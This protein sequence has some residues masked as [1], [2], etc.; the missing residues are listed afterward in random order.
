[1]RIDDCKRNSMKNIKILVVTHK[2]Y[3]MPDDVNLYLPIQ[4][5]AALS[6]SLGIQRDDIGDNISIKNSSYN[7]LCPM[8]WAWKNLDCDYIGVC[9]YRRLFSNTNKSSKNYNDLLS[10]K[11]IDNLLC[12][13]NVVLPRKSRFLVPAYYHYVHCMKGY[14]NVHKEDLANLRK[15]ICEYDAS[16]LK[17]YDKIMHSSK[18]HMFHMCIMKKE[19][20]DEYCNFMFSIMAKVEELSQN[21]IDKTR[22]IGAL[23]EFLLDVWIESQKIEYIELG[24]IEP[25]K[26]FIAKKI[27]QVL[28]RKFGWM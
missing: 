21:R 26:P 22:Y 25:E 19:L 2:P 10:Y 27:I 6:Q 8:Y 3:I 24:I 14:E 17:T 16:Y 23:S 20:Y 11:T 9:H 4:S 12:K 18:L 28:K 1:M 5:G 7:E 15:S 13:T